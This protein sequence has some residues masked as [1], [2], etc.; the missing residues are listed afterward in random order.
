VGLAGTALVVAARQADQCSR[1]GHS[2]H[3]D[4][5][6]SAS[7]SGPVGRHNV[8]VSISSVTCSIIRCRD[9]G[10]EPIF[11]AIE[12]LPMATDGLAL[13]RGSVE[14]LPSAIAGVDLMSAVV[15]WA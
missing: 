4:A 13:S 8:T 3:P 12:G 7:S 9:S 1:G 2:R 5:S 11:P 6:T 14:R 10:Y 15:P